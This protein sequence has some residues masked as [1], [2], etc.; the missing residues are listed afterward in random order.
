MPT[1]IEDLGRIEKELMAIHKKVNKPKIDAALDRVKQAAED[2]HK[3]FSGSWLGYHSRVYYEGLKPVPPGAHFSVEWGMMPLHSIQDTRGDWHEY[4]GDQI[5]EILKKQAG[6]PSMEEISK[7]AAKAVEESKDYREE[8]L[9]IL[10]A[11]LA[12]S[13]DTYLEKMKKQAEASRF[14]SV[15]ECVEKYR[16]KG[17]FMSRDSVAMGQGF[18]TPAHI[19][20]ISQ[21]DAIKSA[22]NVPY[23]VAQTAK[24]VASHLSKKD[25]AKGFSTEQGTK[26]FIGH[27]GSPAWREL[28]DFIQDRLGLEADEFNRKPIAG[29][30]NIARLSEMLGDAAIAFLVMTAEDEMKEG[31][32][33]ARMNVIHE[34]G[35]FQ[36][37]LGFMRAIVLLEEGCEEFSNI[38]G[39]GQIRFPAKRI[40]AAFED[41]RAVLERE[42]LLEA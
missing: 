36:G 25:Q 19:I 15:E 24:R 2:A 34:A 28:K 40:K 18:I 17:Q 27:G 5:L 11:C 10:D 32:V 33:H 9:S 31:K 21:V 41:V 35:L 29:I 39:L 3:A 13:Q 42:G 7:D 37:R 8:L 26:V 38:Q 14:R 16:P 4:D 20:A 30:T 6:S 1:L 12:R 22:L 23:A